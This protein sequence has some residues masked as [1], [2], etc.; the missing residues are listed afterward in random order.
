LKPQFPVGGRLTQF[1]EFWVK[2]CSD[3]W[4]VELIS[5]GYAIEFSSTPPPFSRIR[6]TQVRLSQIPVLEN[7]ISKLLKKR[8]IELVPLGDEKDGFYSTFFLVPKKSGELRPILNLKP[9]NRFIHTTKFRME[10][11]TMVTEA[12]QPGDWLASLDLK[13]AYFHVPIRPSHVRY[14]GAKFQGKTYQFRCLPFGISTAPRVFTKVVAPLIALLRMMGIEVFPFLDDLLFK[15]KSKI[16]LAQNMR[17]GKQIFLNAGFIINMIKSEPEPTQDIIHIGGRFRTDLG[18]I[19]IPPDRIDKI[20]TC[21]R[22]FRVGVSIPVRL[23]LRLLGLM[24]STLG[25][26]Q[27]ARLRMRHLQMFLLNNWSP[28]GGRLDHCL[29]IP[30]W[31]M[32]HLLWW[33]SD[34]HLLLGCPLNPPSPQCT[35]TTDACMSGWG[36]YMDGDLGV[37]GSWDLPDLRSHINVLELRAVRRVIYHYRHQLRGRTVLCQTDNTTVLAYINKQGG[38][39]SNDMCLEAI[40]FWELCIQFQ[41]TPT[42]IHLPGVKNQLADLL[43][44]RRVNQNEWSLKPLIAHQIFQTLGIPDIDLFATFRNKKCPVFM[45]WTPEPQ[46]LG[47]NAFQTNWSTSLGYAFPP[48]K[49]VPKVLQK[50]M[51]DHATV[52]LIAPKWPRRLWYTQI[53]DLLMEIPI[54]LPIEEDLLSQGTGRSRLLHPAPQILQLVAWKVSGD[55]SKVRDFRLRLLKQ[56]CQPAVPTRTTHMMRPGNASWAGAVQGTLIPIQ[57]LYQLL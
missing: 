11:L 27:F 39:K 17:M 45:S 18:I 14:L 30:L 4:V 29:M 8:A 55:P 40:E 1:Q 20:K 41:I 7:E 10:T 49:L 38:T 57:Q 37:Q 24:V 50:I 5:L 56:S 31:L 15:A 36:G 48:V 32:R 13:D 54:E 53:L 9:L 22:P 44:R 21:L 46:T 34:Q 43:S 16:V 51:S 33:N 2:Y 52:I 12:V 28:H 26:T 23:I 35:V 19:Q 25:V 3:Q 47:T 6:E 42:A